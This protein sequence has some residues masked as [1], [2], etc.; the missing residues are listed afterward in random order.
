MVITVIAMRMMKVTIDKVVNVISVWDRFMTT[1]RTMNV[2]G[3]VAAALM[4]W[5]AAIGVGFAD[6]NT[7]FNN[8]PVLCHVMQVAVM[9]VV[10][11]SSVLNAGMFAVRAMLVIMVFVCMAHR[12]FSVEEDLSFELEKTS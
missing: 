11:V 10:N 5:G 12:L 7:V 3:V 1:A 4:S 8:G 9:Q 2:I 6:F